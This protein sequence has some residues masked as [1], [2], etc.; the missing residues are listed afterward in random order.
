[1]SY[2]ISDTAAEILA[3]LQNAQTL[4]VKHQNRLFARDVVKAC[5]L[6]ASKT[7]FPIDTKILDKLA[8]S[9]PDKMSESLIVMFSDV[10]KAIGDIDYRMYRNKVAKEKPGLPTW[11]DLGTL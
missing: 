3:L 4:A 10:I 9:I 5:S 6:Y 2:V 7:S 1:M 11:S 8:I